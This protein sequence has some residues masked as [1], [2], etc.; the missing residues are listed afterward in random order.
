MSESNPREVMTYD[1][2]VVGGGPAGLAC[3]MKTKQ[4][5]PELSVCVIEKAS[6]IGAHILSGAVIET[7]ALE[8]L[9]PNWRDD[10]PPICVPASGDSFFFLK[11]ESAIRLPTPPQQRNHGNVIVSLG[12][13]CAWLAPKAEALGVDLFPGFAAS[14]W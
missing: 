10:P 2:I 3:A 8:E 13:L 11:K 7:D 5:N 4:L 1:V 6:Q 12:A 9:V 14:S